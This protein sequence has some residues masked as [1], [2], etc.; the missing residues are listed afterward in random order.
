[1][2]MQRPSQRSDTDV[3]ASAALLFTTTPPSPLTSF[4]D[5]FLYK[6]RTSTDCNE[7]TDARVE[8]CEGV[9]NNHDV[10]DC[11]Y[12]RGECSAAGVGERE[13]NG[14]GVRFEREGAD[15]LGG[16]GVD[17]GQPGA[18]RSQ[19]GGAES[20]GAQ[21]HSIDIIDMG[22]VSAEAEEAGGTGNGGT[23]SAGATSASAQA[24]MPVVAGRQGVP[25]GQMDEPQPPQPPPFEFERHER[26]LR[27]SSRLSTIQAPPAEQE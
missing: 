27:R 16:E 1:M 22:I 10:G 23:E 25:T 20:E 14:N 13:P 19:V 26:P 24:T 18:S 5:Y 2:H 4:Q 3:C 12:E 11:M 21:L 8:Y 6:T 17:G 9:E 7:S 15:V